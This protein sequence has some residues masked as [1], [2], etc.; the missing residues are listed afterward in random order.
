MLETHL[1]LPYVNQ[2]ASSTF[3]VYTIDHICIYSCFTDFKALMKSNY[4]HI[5]GLAFSLQTY[6]S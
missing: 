3:V 5:S 4:R 6:V 2:L 1:L